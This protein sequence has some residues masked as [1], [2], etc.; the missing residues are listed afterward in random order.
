M[1][2]TRYASIPSNVRSSNLGVSNRMGESTDSSS[3]LSPEITIF[4][5]KWLAKTKKISNFSDCLKF[6]NESRFESRG[7][8]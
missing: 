4:W 1:E 5:V 6:I 7:N 3:S 8:E 2:F